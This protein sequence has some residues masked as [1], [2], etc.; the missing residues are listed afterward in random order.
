MLKVTVCHTAGHSN[1]AVF[2]SRRNCSSGDAERTDSG[3]AFHA[4][5]AATGKKCPTPGT[6]P[7]HGHPSQ[8]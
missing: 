8:Y 6:E 2:R 4:R 7:G 1:S 5:A 3:R